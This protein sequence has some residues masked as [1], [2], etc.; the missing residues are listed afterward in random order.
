MPLLS[1]KFFVNLMIGLWIINIIR[2]YP[3]SELFWFCIDIFV[4]FYQ[5]KHIEQFGAIENNFLL[6]HV[7][8]YGQ[9]MESISRDFTL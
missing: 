9:N 8:S 6:H 1:R 4:L 2:E 3:F 7:L 5:L